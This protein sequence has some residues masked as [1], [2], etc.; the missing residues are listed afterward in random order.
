[1]F[2]LKNTTGVDLILPQMSEDIPPKRIIPPSG[3]FTVNNHVADLLRPFTQIVQIFYE[4]TECHDVES[5]PADQPGAAP[6]GIP[7]HA[8]SSLGCAQPCGKPTPE[9]HDSPLEQ[10]DTDCA[11]VPATT[12]ETA[13]SIESLLDCWWRSFGSRPVRAGQ[14][15][16]QL[17]A[18]LVS[19]L[20]PNRHTAQAKSIAMGHMALSFA[21]QDLRGWKIG[22]KKSGHGRRFSLVPAD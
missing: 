17:P 15:V 22:V 14:I 13:A 4:E 20:F 5:G 11:P 19:S 1:M 3:L 12:S 16:P 2:L 8:E 10:Q 9:S 7:F 21:G 18:S 6:K